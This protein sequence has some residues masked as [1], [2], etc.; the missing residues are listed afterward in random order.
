MNVRILCGNVAARDCN[1]IVAESGNRDRTRGAYCC[2]SL[3]KH[4]KNVRYAHDDR[5][6]LPT[7]DALRDRQSQPRCRRTGPASCRGRAD[8]LPRPRRAWTHGPFDRSDALGVARCDCSA[9][10]APADTGETAIA[11]VR[12]SATTAAD[13]ARRSRRR[14]A[15]IRPRRARVHVRRPGAL[16]EDARSLASSTAQGSLTDNVKYKIGARL[17]YDF[18]YDATDFYPPDVRR[19]QR[20]NFLLRENYLD[21]GAGDWDFRVGRQHIVWG[22]MVGLFFADVVSAKDLREFILPDFDVL[23]IPQWAGA[24]R[25]LQGRLPR[26]G[27]LDPGAELRRH[28]QARRR[29]LSRRRHR[30][31]RAIATLYDNEQFPRAHARRTPTTV[32]GCRCSHNGWDMSGFYYRSMD[33]QP[34]FYRQIVTAP[35]AGIRLSGAA[36]PTSTRSAARSRRTSGRRCSRPKP[37]I[38]AA[39]ATTCCAWTTTTASCGRTRSTS[40]AG[41]TSRCRR[42]PGS[43][44]SCS[45]ARSS[46]T[47]PTS[48]S[49]ATSRDSACC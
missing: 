26:R 16:V 23:R 34:T 13:A 25:I 27:D 38:R 15:R 12:C 40:S 43:T 48:F 20:V 10:T 1:G 45:T 2:T 47:T 9:T 3:H 44:C 5:S 37:S 46:I 24:R 22:E 39:A 30:R 17:D 21:F 8:A 33:A 29:I 14:L 41:S 31:R 28:R 32:C 7:A 42:T 36:R 19:D 11:R 35:A 49:S 4:V 6:D 18:V